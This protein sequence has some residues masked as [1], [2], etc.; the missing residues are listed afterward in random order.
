MSIE[1]FKKE[2]QSLDKLY[3]PTRYP[4][5]L[6]D[7]IPYEAYNEQDALRALEAVNTILEQIEKN[8][9]FK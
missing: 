4:N 3:I 2:A 7:L 9:L 8:L 5:G 1:K 6:P